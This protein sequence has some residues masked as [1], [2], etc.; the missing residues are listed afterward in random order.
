MSHNFASLVEEVK[1]LS[2][3]EKEELKYILEQVILEGRRNQ[4]NRN[5][6]E[7]LKELRTGTLEFSGDAK[8]LRRMMEE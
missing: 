4:I 8:E 2:G 1:R 3:E 5:F 7:S 6:R